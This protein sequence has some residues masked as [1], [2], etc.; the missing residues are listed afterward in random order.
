MS[1]L[2]LGFRSER[3]KGHVSQIVLNRLPE[4][5]TALVLNSMANVMHIARKRQGNGV[6]WGEFEKNATCSHHRLFLT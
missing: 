3:L 6:D 1:W 2:Y 4:V 5:T